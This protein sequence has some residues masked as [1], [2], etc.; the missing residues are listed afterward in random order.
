M[1]ILI[2]TDVLGVANN[3]TTVASYHLAK[4]LRERGHEVTFLCADQSKIGQPGFFV[5]PTINFG[6]LLNAYVA[7]NEV[8]LAKADMKIIQAALEGID[9]VHIMLPFSLGNHTAKLANKLNIPITAGFHCQ[10]ENVSSH[11]YL[12]HSP[13]VNNTIYRVFWKNL[14]RMVDCIH[15]PTKFIQNDFERIVGPTNGYV[16]SNGINESFKPRQVE[17]PDNL[18]D[19][20]VIVTTGRYAREKR[21]IVLLKAMKYSKH[22]KDI[23][24]ILAGD[25]PYR[26]QYL[27][28]SKKLTNKPIFGLHSKDELADI[29]CYS[30]LYVHPAHAELESIACLE[31]I[32]AGLVP[33]I[34]NSKR[35][36]PRYFALDEKNLYK[37]NNPKV[38][39]KQI[40]YWFEHPEERKQRQKDYEHFTDKF[41]Y[42][43]CM[44]RMEKMILE[45]KKIRQYKIDNNIH[46][47][48]VLYEDPLHDDFAGTNI[49]TKKVD[50][51]FVYIHDNKL[52]KFFSKIIYRGIAV[53]ILR[54]F[55]KMK[56]GVKVKNPKAIKSLKGK[57]YFIY[58]NHTQMMDAFI[59]HT[60]VSKKNRTYIVANPDAV[61][62]KGLQNF[63]MMMGCLPLPS[64]A[65]TVEAF[66]NAIKT[67]I[68]EKGV[69]VIYPEAHIW[70]FYEGIREFGD[71]SFQY[72]AKL[73][74]P[75]VAMVTTYRKSKHKITKKRRPYIDITLS[76]PIYPQEG[77]SVKENQKYLRDQ[78]Y[79]F[80]KKTIEEANKVNYINYVK[81]DKDSTRFEK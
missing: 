73:N 47:R 37:R 26:F 17:K 52:W 72:P 20:F 32:K 45:A 39:A 61:S 81:G 49:V 29:L 6:K 54:L 5:C 66:Q 67:R 3:G 50:D 53:P 51:D 77:L 75:V 10:C 42:E 28:A 60:M 69:V 63:V 48:V 68:N 46:H 4:S 56:R 30:D 13:L 80:M 16:I 64:T 14:Y 65:Q 43:H 59:P 19:K 62:I 31:A 38:L 40:D 79:E 15:Y 24:L 2:V 27:K 8:T 36:A 58:G 57:G 34:N 11:F 23:Q 21:Q 78:V 33:V 9:H 35:A 71:V 25:G 7:K 22:E 76:N 74:A 1:K 12:M 44:D 70:P 55:A 18:K 41:E